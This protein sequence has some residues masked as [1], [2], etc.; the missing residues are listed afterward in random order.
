MSDDRSRP[1]LADEREIPPV[2]RAAEDSRLLADTVIGYLDGDELVLDLGT[3]TGYVGRRIASETGAS[4]IGSDI[5]PHACR[6]AAG[7]GLAVIRGDLLGPI[8]TEAVDIV[9]FNP[10]YLPTSPDIEWDDWQERALSGGETGRAIIEPFLEDCRRVV[11]RG[12][13]AFLLVSSLTGI[14][15]VRDH[16]RANGLTTAIAAEEAHPGERL[17]VIH[18]V[19]SHGNNHDA[20]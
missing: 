2:Y 9:V 19:P 14:E 16:A 5:N 12:G 7:D 11:R 18:L 3:G 4:V 15:A 13:A 8:Q 10:P 1:R 17:V 20:S 6:A